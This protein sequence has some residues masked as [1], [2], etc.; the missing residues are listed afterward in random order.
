LS[1]NRST[2]GP[3]CQPTDPRANYPTMSPIG[4]HCF[5]RRLCGFGGTTLTLGHSRF[6]RR[7]PGATRQCHVNVHRE[8]PRSP[9]GALPPCALICRIPCET[10]CNIDMDLQV[11]THTVELQ[12]RQRT[13]ASH[14][15]TMSVATFV[16]ETVSN[17]CS[18]GW[19]AWWSQCRMG[20]RQSRVGLSRSCVSGIT[21]GSSVTLPVGLTAP[22]R[23]HCQSG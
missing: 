16:V 13:I 21:V 1:R 8:L 4:T 22:R 14:Q 3:P 5:G 7:V 11:A 15:V 18:A 23:S 2:V 10:P 12:L 6:A 19:A 20:G 17:G 9:N